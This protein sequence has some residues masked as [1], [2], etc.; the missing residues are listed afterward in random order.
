MATDS[1]GVGAGWWRAGW[2]AVAGFSAVVVVV[3]VGVPLSS[4]FTT[5]T[6]TTSWSATHSI[7]AVQVNVDSADVTVQPAARGGVASLHQKLTWSLKKPQV[8]ESWQGATL[9]ITEHCDSRTLF[10]GDSCGA[11]LDLAVA[12]TVPVHVT[13]D[14]GSVIVQQMTGSLRVEAISGDVELDSVTG[15]VWARAESGSINGDQLRSL[16]VDAQTESGDLTLR[17]AASPGTVSAS[18]L[19]GS[20]N[21]TVP[22]GT[23]YRVTGRTLSG[24]RQ[25]ADGLVNDNS[26]RSMALDSESGDTT[27]GYAFGQ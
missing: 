19:S 17:F 14:S 10:E 12:A 21:V 13:A 2:L 1:V 23:T 3:A 16:H 6:L 20:V 26:P 9:V 24:G 18:A 5:Q 7:D 11:T 22:P 25:I 15:S 8:T 27:L 4:R